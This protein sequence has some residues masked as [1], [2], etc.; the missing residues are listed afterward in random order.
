MIT[1]TR[2]FPITVCSL[3]CCIGFTS[4]T[5]KHVLVFLLHSLTWLYYILFVHSHFFFGSCNELSLHLVA[6][7]RTDLFLVLKVSLG[8]NSGAIRSG[9]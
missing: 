2:E 7:I 8:S 3:L 4:A 9:F 1:T 5:S 6:Y